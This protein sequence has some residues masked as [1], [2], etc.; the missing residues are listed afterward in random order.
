MWNIGRNTPFFLKP[1]DAWNPASC[2]DLVGLT[3]GE[4]AMILNDGSKARGRS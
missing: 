3:V 1:V 2:A 4:I